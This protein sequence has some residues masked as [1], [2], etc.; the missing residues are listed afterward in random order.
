MPVVTLVC[1]IFSLLRRADMVRKSTDGRWSTPAPCFT[2]ADRRRNSPADIRSLGVLLLCRFAR[3]AG[4]VT[5]CQIFVR[6]RQSPAVGG[7]SPCRSEQ[8]RRPISVDALGKT[9][10]R[11]RLE[12]VA[13]SGVDN[14]RF[15]LT[16]TTPAKT[17]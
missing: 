14:P 7:G 12:K 1:V 13:G 15:Q 4:L 8:P 5:L 16:P 2:H 3:R 9:A 11:A 10:R 17:T 6:H